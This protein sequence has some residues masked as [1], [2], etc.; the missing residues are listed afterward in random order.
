MEEQLSCREIKE[1][2]GC[3][4]DQFSTLRPKNTKFSAIFEQPLLWSRC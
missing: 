4:I 1:Y 3:L 2:T